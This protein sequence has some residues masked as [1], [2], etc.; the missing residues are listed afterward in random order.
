MEIARALP[1]RLCIRVNWGAHSTP[2]QAVTIA[3]AMRD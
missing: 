3:A 1:W 2:E